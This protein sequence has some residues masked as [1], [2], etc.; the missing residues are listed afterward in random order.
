MPLRLEDFGQFFVAALL[1]D[2]QELKQ[3]ITLR[4]QVLCSR[5]LCLLLLC[6]QV[7]HLHIG[8]DLAFVQD[9]SP[10]DQRFCLLDLV[11]GQNQGVLLTEQS[12]Q[13]FQ[14]VL[15]GDQIM[16]KK[17]LVSVSTLRSVRQ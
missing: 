4:R 10:A 12:C 8:D 17:R 14:G 2:L 11:R 16:S 9:D 3:A 1:V 7:F 15:A 5:V 13:Q 6:P